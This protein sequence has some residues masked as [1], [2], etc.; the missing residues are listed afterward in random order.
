[1]AVACGADAREQQDAVRQVRL[2][3]AKRYIGAHL[4]DP[5]L[6]PEKA[7]AALKMSVRQLHVLFEPSSTTFG[8]YVRQ[9]RL[10]ECHA[11]LM[12]PIGDRSV[13]DIALAWGFNSLATFH[14]NFRQAFGATPGEVR[15]SAA[16][17][18]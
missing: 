17:P 9:R 12:N 8:E 16:I 3:E 4:A 5:G 14:R 18:R 7:A 11:A 13:T 15:V 2:E 10:E 1:L 6:T